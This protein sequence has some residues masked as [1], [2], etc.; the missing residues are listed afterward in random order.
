MRGYTYLQLG[1]HGR[2]GN[3]LW[4]IASTW[5]IAQR[6]GKMVAFPPWEFSDWFNI[7]DKLFTE[8]EDTLNNLTNLYPD[9][10]QDLAHLSGYEKDIKLHFYPS[11][12]ALTAVESLYP[13]THLG[14][15]TA[16]HVRRGDYLG[17]PHHHPVCGIG[18]YERAL[19]MLSPSEIMV[20]S[21]D[22][23]WCKQQPLF[24]GAYFA[25]GNEI[26]DLITM[27]QCDSFVIAN[28]T[29]SWWGAWLADQVS[30][31]VCYPKRWYGPE[32]PADYTLMVDGLGWTGVD[33]HPDW[34]IEFDHRMMR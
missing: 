3:Q 23:E 22:I 27:S 20:F 24:K 14:N 29:F 7:P 13:D 8:D 9:Y 10:L 26:E 2:L 4:Q 30:E 1:H 21:D 12:M 5:A 25:R 32:V 28:S 6:A 18:Y 16:V 17:L 33:F 31:R 34:P 15:M 19:N 11:V